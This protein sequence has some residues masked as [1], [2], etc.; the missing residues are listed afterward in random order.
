MASTKRKYRGGGASQ[1]GAT[2]RQRGGSGDSSDDGV[3]IKT[4]DL[5]EDTVTIV[6]RGSE[7]VS[8]A[9][10][11]LLSRTGTQVCARCLPCTASV[12]VP[13]CDLRFRVV[14]ALWAPTCHACACPRHLDSRVSPAQHL[15]HE[16]AM[17][18]HLRSIVMPGAG[19]RVRRRHGDWRRRGADHLVRQRGQE[20]VQRRGGGEP[21]L[22]EPLHLEQRWGHRRAG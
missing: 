18:A 9:G 3:I 6:N 8:L 17:P 2:K 16:V 11:K 20:A 14:A 5:I 12:G 7:Q 19:V 1:R 22:D 13:A 10:W 21:V 4:L 15:L